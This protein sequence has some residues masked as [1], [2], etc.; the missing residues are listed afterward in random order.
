[1][2]IV[3]GFADI[4]VAQ[5]L[6]VAGVALFASVIG[7]LA[8]YGTGALMPLVLVPLIGAEPVVP[9][10]AISSIF[11]NLSR[12]VAYIR[13][14]DRR[15]AL[16]VVS[17]AILTTALGAYGYTRLSG[18]GAAVVIG[19]MLILSVPLRR[20][21]KRRDIRIGDAGLAAS[22]V[23]YGLVVGGTSGS[24]VIL[25]SLLMAAGLEGAAV[26]ATDAVI[27]L[28]TS[29]VKISVFGLAGVV[30]A[31][32]LAF[33]LLIGAVAIPGA[34]LAK[35]FVE[36][37]PVHIHTAILDAAVITGG[38]VMISSALRPVW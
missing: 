6:L 26:I 29:V 31:Q 21:A 20:L 30:T 13:Y 18:A 16:I 34:F 8:G 5:L 35:T 2:N 10:I 32:V 38:L 3:S 27:S 22:A 14:A 28:A 9:I 4:S 25:L 7:G 17:A 1:M 12:F 11:T 19:S 33:A 24:G 23:G 37:M 36:R 15:R